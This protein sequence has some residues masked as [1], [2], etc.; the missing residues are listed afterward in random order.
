MCAEND[1][2][3]TNVTAECGP[4]VCWSGWWR[5]LDPGQRPCDGLVLW[6][7]ALATCFPSQEHH[8]S[9]MPICALGTDPFCAMSPPGSA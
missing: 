7:R 5:Q 8:Q 9:A 2:I 3:G 6:R 4:L 1:C